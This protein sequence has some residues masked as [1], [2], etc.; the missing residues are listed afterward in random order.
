MG[1]LSSCDRQYGPENW[2]RNDTEY[3]LFLLLE[4]NGPTP[5]IES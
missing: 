4:K 1:E 2:I 5:E 3:V